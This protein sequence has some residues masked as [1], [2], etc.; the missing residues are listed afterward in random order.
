MRARAVAAVVVAASVLAALTAASATAQASGT[1]G[2]VAGFGITTSSGG[3]KVVAAEAGRMRNTGANTVML[4]ATWVV[5]SNDGNEIR[6]GPGTVTDADLLAAAQRAQSVGMS[7]ML[8]TKI[9]CACSIRWRGSL[10]PS[11]RAAFFDSYRQM[12][13]HYATLAQQIGAVAYFVGSEMNSTQGETAQW[14]QVITEARER[15]Q[16]SNRRIGYQV[17]WDTMREVGFWDEVDIAGLSVYTP[18]SD[19]MQPNV[20]DLLKAWRS[21]DTVAWRGTDWFEEIRKF[22]QSHGKPVLFGE[23][24]YQS[25]SQATQRPWQQEK[26]EQW[27]PQLQA[28]AYQA[29]LTTFESQP[30]WL[31]AIWWEWKITSADEGDM[32]Y[33]PRGKLAEELLTKWYAENQRPA[34]PETSLVGVT[35]PSSKGQPIPPESLKGPTSPGNRT[36]V[37]RPGPTAEATKSQSAPGPSKGRATTDPALLAPPVEAAAPPPEELEAAPTEEPAVAEPPALA[38]VSAGTL[39]EALARAQAREE[40]RRAA[41]AASA[42]LLSTLLGHAVLLGRRALPWALER[43]VD[44]T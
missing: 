16:G 11:N 10:Y 15:Y 41:L 23:I 18:L 21:S 22:A 7:V 6:R 32:D 27:D 3:D 13:N 8:T 9:A 5:D 2:K 4:E 34:S 29:A 38:S 40:L 24:G 42:L 25:A 33:S 14:R 39:E 35:R 30:W 1:R 17:N 12:T 44:E 28:D 37:S 31:G 36:E 26:I 20:A 43:W 19:A